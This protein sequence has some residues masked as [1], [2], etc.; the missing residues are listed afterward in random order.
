M[1]CYQTSKFQNQNFAVKVGLRRKSLV[2]NK[3]SLIKERKFDD[4][5]ISDF[6]INI[7]K[8]TKFRIFKVYYCNKIIPYSS[9]MRIINMRKKTE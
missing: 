9:C 3:K 7:I 6:F 5:Q 8:K 2:F 4:C 1:N